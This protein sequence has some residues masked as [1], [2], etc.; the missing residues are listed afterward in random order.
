MLDI[1]SIS[2]SLSHRITNCGTTP[3]GIDQS[4]HTATQIQFEL[5]TIAW[6]CHG[7]KTL[8]LW[9]GKTDWQAINL[10]PTLRQEYNSKISE[11]LSLNP[12]QPYTTFFNTTIAEAAHTTA[13]TL[14]CPPEDWFELSKHLLQPTIIN[15]LSTLRAIHRSTIGPPNLTLILDIKLA[16]KLQNIA[17]EKQNACTCAH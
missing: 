6:K 15:K 4:D 14:E 1:F 9:E 17:S 13:T 12:L 5:N 3:K 7:I 2:S 11:S 8:P 16:T 10:N